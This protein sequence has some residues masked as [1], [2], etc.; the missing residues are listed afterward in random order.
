MIQSKTRYKQNQSYLRSKFK[1]GCNST[2][3]VNKTIRGGIHL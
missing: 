2:K 3:K 1:R